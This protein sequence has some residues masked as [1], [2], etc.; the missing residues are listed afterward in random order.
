LNVP[1][2]WKNPLGGKKKGENAEG[3]TVKKR[4][5]THRDQERDKKASNDCWTPL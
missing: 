2:K 3:W 1:A 5:R 4:I